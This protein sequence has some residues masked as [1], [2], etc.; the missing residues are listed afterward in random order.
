MAVEGRAHQRAHPILVVF[1]IR[2]G[3]VS[4]KDFGDLDMTCRASFDERS[5]TTLA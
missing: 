3:T 2:L 5:P 4:Q 1:V